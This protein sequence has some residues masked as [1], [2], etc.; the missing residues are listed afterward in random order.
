M[1][2][3]YC[4]AAPDISGSMVAAFQGKWEEVIPLLKRWGY[5]GVELVIRD[6]DKASRELLGD[7]CNEN[8][9]SVAMVCT[10]Q[11]FAEEGLSFLHR[12]E[13]IRQRAIARMREVIDFASPFQCP[14]NIGRIRGNLGEGACRERDSQW[15][16]ECLSA[17]AAYAEERQVVLAIEPLNRFQGNYVNTTLEGVELVERVARGGLQLMID[18]FHMNIEDRSLEESIQKAAHHIIHVHVCDSNRRAPGQGHLDFWPIIEALSSI[19]YEGFVSGE[20]LP[21][22]DHR[23]AARV[24]AEYMKPLISRA[25]DG[26]VRGRRIALG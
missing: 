12:E 25:K 18:L 3:G 13:A 16:T 5:Q 8:Q 1:K 21:I 14:V 26:K 22:P 23:T 9:I 6:P 20:V 15:V 11:I 19:S 4:I 24:T 10:G 2:L 7:L 17:L